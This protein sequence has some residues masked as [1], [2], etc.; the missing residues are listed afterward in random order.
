VKLEKPRPRSSALQIDHLE[1]NAAHLNESL[2][3]EIQQ[4]I[5]VPNLD[6]ENGAPNTMAFSESQGPTPNAICGT[7]F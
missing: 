2:G 1:K 5:I 7:D 3:P 4:S 6:Y